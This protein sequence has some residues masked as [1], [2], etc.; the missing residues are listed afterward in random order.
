L[1]LEGAWRD[2]LSNGY[3]LRAHHFRLNRAKVLVEDLFVLDC[4]DS[5]HAAIDEHPLEAA[6]EVAIDR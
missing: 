5:M 3:W 4:E 6:S 2:S 1:K